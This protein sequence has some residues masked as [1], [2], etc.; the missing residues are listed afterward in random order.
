MVS[1]IYMERDSDILASWRA[2]ESAMGTIYKLNDYCKTILNVHK[3]NY[4]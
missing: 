2:N 1:M 4:I 3:Y